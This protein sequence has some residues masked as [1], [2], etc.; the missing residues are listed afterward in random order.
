MER[1]YLFHHFI[2]FMFMPEVMELLHTV[3]VNQKTSLTQCCSVLL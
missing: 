2:I 1:V 3:E